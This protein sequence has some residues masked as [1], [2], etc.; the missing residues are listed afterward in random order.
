MKVCVKKE[1]CRSRE[2]CTGSTD[3]HISIQNL[4]VKEIVGLVHNTQDPL[5]DNIPCENTV[6]N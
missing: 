3:K 2:Q 1:V 4:L 5:I 6:L